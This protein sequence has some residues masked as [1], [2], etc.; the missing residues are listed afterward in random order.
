M[1]QNFAPSGNFSPQRPHIILNLRDT[2]VQRMSLSS[3]VVAAGDVK[4]QTL[5]RLSQPE[6][7]WSDGDTRKV[8]Y[9]F[10]GLTFMF[11]PI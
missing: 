7:A 11:L 1:K 10:A 4:P 6:N 9:D 8:T 2:R 5:I 3:L